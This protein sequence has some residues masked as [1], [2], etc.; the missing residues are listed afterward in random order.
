MSYPAFTLLILLLN[1]LPTLKRRNF[2]FCNHNLPEGVCVTM[3]RIIIFYFFEIISKQN[4]NAY[5]LETTNLYYK[6]Q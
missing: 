6:H 2:I 4:I 3:Y 5:L 1:C